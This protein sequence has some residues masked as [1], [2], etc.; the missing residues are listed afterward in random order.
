M[1]SEE[2]LQPKTDKP[3]NLPRGQVCWQVTHF[4]RVP[5]SIRPAAATDA[6]AISQLR[7]GMACRGST[8]SS[9]G[10]SG[11]TALA[12]DGA[13]AKST[14]GIAAILSTSHATPEV[15]GTGYQFA[16]VAEHEGRVVAAVM[17]PPAMAQVIPPCAGTPCPHLA[18]L[19]VPV[20]PCT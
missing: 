7:D 20:L 8:A 5:L 1:Q 10:A 9:A 3:T 17:A 12:A 2:P 15:E 4:I 16:W 11:G 6:A 19:Q 18:Q 14:A 13:A